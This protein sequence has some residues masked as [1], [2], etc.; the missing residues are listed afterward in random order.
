MKEQL[1]L[2]LSE[3]Q[4]ILKRSAHEYF[5]SKMPVAA[6]RALRDCDND[7]GLD[8]G[9]W[10]EMADMGWSGILVPEAYGGSDFGY[11]GCG[12]IME[13][14]G[15]CLAATP[16]LSTAILAAPIL[17]RHASEAL[18]SERL[19]GLV[20]GSELATLALDE[21]VRHA[22][23]HIA[24]RAR[25][26]ATG[27]RLS[28]EKI[29]VVDGH[30]ADYIIVLARTSGAV[31]ASDGL[32]LFCVPSAT[33]GLKRT[34]THLVD[35]RNYASLSF[36]DVEV[37]GTALLGP[38]DKAFDALTPILD[39]AR[40][41]LAA[42][43]LGAAS[44]AFDRTLNYLR[45]REQFGVAIGSFQALKHR[46][47]VMFC[48]LE[49]TRS[50]VIAALSS[51]DEQRADCAELASLAKT[52]AAETF[53]LVSNEAVQMHGGIGMTDE[54][55]IGFFLKRARVAQQLFGD[56]SFHRARYADLVGL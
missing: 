50:A 19:P 18:K 53:E 10:Q 41:L 13:E 31:D 42:E 34:R 7:D 38:L 15:R 56:A 25:T 47:A 54:E 16:L 27:F 21:Q 17:S 5:T 35:S 9:A 33:S 6:L 48:E 4:T 3:E 49:L 30:I 14:A 36:N 52:K 22:P 20:A 11:L 29:A 26:S 37:Q 24:L 1:N 46:A 12:Q 40:A 39:G 23:G 8:R 55:E 2:V 43:M 28:G 44:E 51:L 45:M 32:S